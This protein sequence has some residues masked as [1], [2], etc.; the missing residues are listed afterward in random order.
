MASPGYKVRNPCMEPTCP[1]T[2][3]RPILARLWAIAEQPIAALDKT[4]TVWVPYQK[5]FFSWG[6]RPESASSAIS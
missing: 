3:P 6:T 2:R 5:A 4:R 1:A